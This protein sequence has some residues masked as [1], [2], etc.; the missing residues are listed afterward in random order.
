M[1]DDVEHEYGTFIKRLTEV[2]SQFTS[3]REVSS[4]GTDPMSDRDD[5]HNQAYNSN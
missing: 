1:T 5:K 4:R 3:Q 2:Q